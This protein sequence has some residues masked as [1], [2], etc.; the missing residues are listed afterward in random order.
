MKNLLLPQQSGVCSVHT[1]VRVPVPEKKGVL[2]SRLGAREE[3]EPEFVAVYSS[4]FFIL[5][6]LHKT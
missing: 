3:Q 4:F 5:R 2:I 1:L 6:Q